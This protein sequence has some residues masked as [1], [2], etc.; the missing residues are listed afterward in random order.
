VRRLC[1]VLTVALACV[2]PLPGR[3]RRG[4]ALRPRDSVG[5]LN[6]R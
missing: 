4:A 5:N 3:R 1:V 2:G 6:A